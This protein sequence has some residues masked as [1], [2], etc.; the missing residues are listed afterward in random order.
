M[1][2]LGLAAA[3]A[4]PIPGTLTEFGCFSGG[5]GGSSSI[6]SPDPWRESGRG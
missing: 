3:L 2:R 6:W 4:L 1:L 5:G